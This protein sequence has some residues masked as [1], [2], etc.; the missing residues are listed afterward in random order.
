MKPLT[1]INFQLL[2]HICIIAIPIALQNVLVNCLN[3]MDTLMLSRFGENPVAAVG[4]ANQPFF[5]STMI[6]FGLSCGACVLTSQYYGVG[7]WEAIRKVLSIAMSMALVVGI[8]IFL[9]LFFF[10]QEVMGFYTDKP[11]LI[12]MGAQYLRI[13]SFSYF[14]MTLSTTYLG[15]VVSI[16]APQLP[17]KINVLALVLN[18]T[19]N[20]ILIFGL[21]GFPAL[22][23]RG[24]AIATVIAR[25]VEFAL[26]A[27]F[28][29][30]PRSLVRLR[31]SDLF[32]FDRPLFQDYIR[33]GMPVLCNEFLWGFGTSLYS[34]ILG[35]TSEFVVTAYNFVL[36]VERMVNAYVLGIGR[37]AGVLV[38]MEMGR[39]NP[40]EAYRQARYMLVFAA[41]MGAL[42]LLIYLF[43]RILVGLPITAE[44]LDFEPA[45]M[46]A[47]SAMML[48]EVLIAIP[49]GVQT[50]CIIGVLRGGGDTFF[51]TLADTGPIYLGCLP[52]GFLGFKLGA[53]VFVLYLLLRSDDIIKLC[54]VLWRF[55]SRRWMRNVTRPG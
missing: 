14:F 20:A 46:Q 12:E 7:N 30:G 1:L 36:I 47:L 29:F 45:T 40:K 17:L 10:P 3:M 34:V 19:L 8:S 50:V 22:E 44:L 25:M 51:A 18:T 9:L 16:G 39:N 31:L 48:V 28:L 38:G 55:R 24:A 54:L 37:A 52:L 33:Y 4:L 49:R 21:L 6:I 13:A 41:I 11:L 32:H 53:P 15:I 23:V 5:I 42:S 35:H 27:Y 43:L 2:R 26:V